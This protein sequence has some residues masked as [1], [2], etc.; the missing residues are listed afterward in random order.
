M[1]KI[2]NKE[3][4]YGEFKE[5]EGIT[6]TNWRGEKVYSFK[7]SDEQFTRPNITYKFIAKTSYRLNGKVKNDSAYIM[8]YTYSDFIDGFMDYDISKQREESIKEKFSLNDEQYQDL[9]D[10]FY[11]KVDKIGEQI[12]KHYHASAEYET[13]KRIQSWI[14]DWNTQR[15]D[16]NK[17]YGDG[18]YEKIY[19][20]NGR[21]CEPELLKEIQADYKAKKEY[22]QKC[23]EEQYKRYSEYTSGSQLFNSKG[24]Y[25]NDEKALLKKFYRTLAQKFH[26]D[27]IGEQD[28][29]TLINKL[30]EEWGV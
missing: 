12:E 30:K 7:K 17:K 14:D 28:A 8:S 1:R 21:C 20:F 13:H 15:N 3:I 18:I 19:N 29:M 16:F 11:E 5:V 9:L 22:E 25:S 2:Q 10:L 23:Y 4:V 6:T 26:P 27:V 24:A